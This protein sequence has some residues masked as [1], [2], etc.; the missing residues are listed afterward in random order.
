[1]G[2]T[3][4]CRVGMFH[5]V[6]KVTMLRR[7]A[8]GPAGLAAHS[9]ILIGLTGLLAVLSAGLDSGCRAGLGCGMLNAV[10]HEHHLPDDSI[11]G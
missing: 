5:M 6:A 7:Q 11:A 2:W 10:W 8:F 9:K 3:D 4:G 1:M